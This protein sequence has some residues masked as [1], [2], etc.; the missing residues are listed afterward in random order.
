MATLFGLQNAPRLQAWESGDLSLDT[1]PVF[2][3]TS[4]QDHDQD[5]DQD[6]A[7]REP[8]QM[9]LVTNLALSQG[10]SFAAVTADAGSP[11]S[12]SP[13]AAQPSSQQDGD[14]TVLASSAPTGLLASFIS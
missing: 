2:P 4:P 13:A 5:Q 12:A 8:G 7:M 14:D 10:W 11:E 9:H 1:P 3:A 6:Q